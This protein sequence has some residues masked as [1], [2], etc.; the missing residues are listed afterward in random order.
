LHPI[1]GWGQIGTYLINFKNMNVIKTCFIFYIF[2]LILLCAACTTPMRV[3]MFGRPSINDAAI[4]SCDTVA[5]NPQP[6]QFIEQTAYKPLP[7]IDYWIK[8]SSNAD[9]YET[10]EEFFKA[11]QTS[12]FLVIRNDSILYENYFNGYQREQPVIIFSL[13]K[14][15]TTALVGIAIKEGYFK[16]TQQRVVEFIPAFAAD[17]RRDITLEHLMQMSSGLN[18][19]D[20]KD[21]FKLAALYYNNQLED[22]IKKTKLKYKPGTHFAYKSLD[23]QILGL[24][25]EKATGKRLSDYLAEKLWQPLGME[26]DALVTLDHAGGNAR[27]YG[28]MAA[29]ARDL[30]KIG[31]LYLNNGNWNGKQIVPT[32]W[33]TKS[34]AISDTSHWWGYATGW[35]LNTYVNQNL[36]EKQDFVAAGFSG[37]RIYVDPESNV[38]IVRQGNSQKNINWTS[39]CARLNSLLNHCT[40]RTCDISEVNTNLFAG[41]YKAK[42]GFKFSVVRKGENKWVVRSG[43]FRTVLRQES[44]QCLFSRRRQHRYIFETDKDQKNVVGLYWDNLRKMTYCE[45]VDKM[46]PKTSIFKQK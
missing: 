44:P 26:C 13:S 46:K 35:W 29:C 45:K 7:D 14:A 23:T 38:I 40:P 17:G 10:P 8:K 18:V 31:R 27:S 4:F 39:T 20:H 16:N 15:I 9:D 5:A 21:F 19:S 37:Q 42:G 30:A 11:T 33:I 41:Y 34:T 12:A 36:Y 24:C 25:L 32:D 22:Y 1:S 28:G 6:F 43:L 2:S 3:V